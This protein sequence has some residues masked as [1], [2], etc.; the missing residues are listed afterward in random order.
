LQERN[1]Y[2]RWYDPLILFGSCVVV[3]VLIL[4]VVIVKT[5]WDIFHKEEKKSGCSS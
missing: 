3:F 4:S 5:I 2:D 1:D